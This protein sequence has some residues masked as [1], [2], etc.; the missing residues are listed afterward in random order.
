MSL[1]AFAAA[2]SVLT[3]GIVLVLVAVARRRRRRA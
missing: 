1:V 3:T 2:G